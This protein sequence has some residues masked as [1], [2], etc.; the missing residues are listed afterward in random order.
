MRAHNGVCWSGIFQPSSYFLGSEPIL[1]P[2]GDALSR[3][4]F[5][6]CMLDDMCS[7]DNV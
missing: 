1:R 6:S 4:I 2:A 3:A 7:R 5:G